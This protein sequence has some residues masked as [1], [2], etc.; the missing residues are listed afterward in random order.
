MES[1]NYRKNKLIQNPIIVVL[2]VIIVLLVIFLIISN[3]FFSNDIK[4]INQKSKVINLSSQFYVFN[5][6]LY[7]ITPEKTLYEHTFNSEPEK[8]EE[9]TDI[10]F[11]HDNMQIDKD[12]S[13]YINKDGILSSK[14]IAQ[15]EG[16]VSGSYSDT[17]TAVINKDGE[18][19]ITSMI[20]SHDKGFY[21][22]ELPTDFTEIQDIPKVKKVICCLKITFFLTYD[23][24]VYGREMI[25]DENTYYITKFPTDNPIVDIN[26]SNNTLIALDNKGDVNLIGPSDFSSG[27]VIPYTNMQF[28][29]VS[30]NIKEISSCHNHGFVL[31]K[32]G[33]V[34]FW[35]VRCIGKASDEPY[36]GNIKGI[37]NADNIY[38]SGLY[39]YV[40]KN[41]KIK[42]VNFHY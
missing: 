9:N 42:K 32:S 16:A 28:E 40:L 36:S 3:T 17:H 14:K 37:W 20:D 21:N 25:S 23:G 5:G 6:N 27:D 31:N 35:G 15:I 30:T 4:P 29:N 1:T 24:E 19:F 39:L 2:S 41:D 8:V 38:S 12:G 18:L 33:R 13:I 34:H 26:G 11:L 7:E 22:M 10:I